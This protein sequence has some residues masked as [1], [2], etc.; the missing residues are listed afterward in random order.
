MAAEGLTHSG[1]E[2]W[3]G[4]TNMSFKQTQENNLQPTNT[5]TR[6]EGFSF[7]SLPT[8]KYNAFAQQALK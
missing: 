6:Q 7:C 4:E 3:S 1:S 2:H 5:G 8:S